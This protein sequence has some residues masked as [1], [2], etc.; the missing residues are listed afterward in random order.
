MV[1]QL[2]IFD[3][4][5]FSW[6]KAKALKLWQDRRKEVEQTGNFKTGHSGGRY[7]SDSYS[8]DEK[9]AYIQKMITLNEGRE[10]ARA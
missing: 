9:I 8:M 6:D 1:E 2:M 5:D 7:F 4:T 3:M 10:D